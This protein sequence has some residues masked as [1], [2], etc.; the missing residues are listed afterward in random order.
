[1][2]LSFGCTMCTGWAVHVEWD[3]LREGVCGVRAAGGVLIAARLCLGSNQL[4]VPTCAVIELHGT[5]ECSV[6]L[7]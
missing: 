5:Y 1:M 7:K 3:E 2:Q 6:S 4:V